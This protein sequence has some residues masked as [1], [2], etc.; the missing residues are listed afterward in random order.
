MIQYAIFFISQKIIEKSIFRAFTCL[1]C[2]KDMY[3]HT[4]HQSAITKDSL[5]KYVVPTQLYLNLTL[6]R[7]HSQ[8][9]AAVSKFR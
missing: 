5:S 4:F 1:H 2:L 6:V 7:V 3:L 8:T 9:T